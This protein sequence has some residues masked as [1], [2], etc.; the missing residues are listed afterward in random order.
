MSAGDSCH[1]SGSVTCCF[2]NPLCKA[3]ILIWPCIIMPETLS[4]PQ[5]AEYQGSHVSGLH[6]P[7]ARLD[8][9][10]TSNAVVENA[11]NV[12]IPCKPAALCKSHVAS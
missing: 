10:G 5:D 8:L 11:E 1:D 2:G 3:V 4:G 9:S 12:L 7:I 6:D